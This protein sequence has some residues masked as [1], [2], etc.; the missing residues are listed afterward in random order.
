MLKDSQ[1]GRIELKMKQRAH[2]VH[3]WLQVR[4]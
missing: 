3:Q 4:N 2:Q 1:D